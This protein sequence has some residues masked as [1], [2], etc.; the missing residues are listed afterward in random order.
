MIFFIRSENCDL[1]K[2]CKPAS[3]APTLVYSI[4]RNGFN[5]FRM[6]TASAQAIVLALMILLLT[7]CYFWLERRLVVY[8]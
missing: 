4:Y 2:A 7:L 3:N 5:F 6:G 8:D 1:K